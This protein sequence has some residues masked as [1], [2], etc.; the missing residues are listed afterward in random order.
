MMNTKN[1]EACV[2]VMMTY[3]EDVKHANCSYWVIMFAQLNFIIIWTYEVSNM[4]LS[5]NAADLVCSITHTYYYKK[6]DCID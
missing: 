5:N 4:S 6:L 3:G 1:N 2:V